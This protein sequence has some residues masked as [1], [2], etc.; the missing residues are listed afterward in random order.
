MIGAFRRTVP[1][2]KD[3]DVS[4]DAVFVDDA[5]GVQVAAAVGCELHPIHQQ[6]KEA[7]HSG[8]I[9]RET[10]GVLFNRIGHKSSMKDCKVDERVRN[11]PGL[12]AL[13]G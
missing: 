2:K 13:S 7:I 8:A 12:Y 11:V 5:A 1:A 6:P 9:E 4:V 10:R 3:V